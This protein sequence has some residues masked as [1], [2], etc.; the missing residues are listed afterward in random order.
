MRLEDT[1]VSLMSER[2]RRDSE[3]VPG[4]PDGPFRSARYTTTFSAG[5]GYMLLFLRILAVGVIGVLMFA[6]RQYMTRP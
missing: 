4:A 6:L 2:D 1:L 3:I 5:G